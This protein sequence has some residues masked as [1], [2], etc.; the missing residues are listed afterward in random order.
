MANWCAIGMTLTL[1]NE[2]TAK[3]LYNSLPSFAFTRE[4]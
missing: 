4:L 3:K 2:E 1:E